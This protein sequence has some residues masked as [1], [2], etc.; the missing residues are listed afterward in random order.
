MRKIVRKVII[1]LFL[2]LVLSINVGFSE[3]TID[4]TPVPSIEEQTET[5]LIASLEQTNLIEKILQ[6]KELFEK[7]LIEEQLRQEELLKEQQELL[8]QEELNAIISVCNIYCD[9]SE[10]YFVDTPIQYTDEEKQLLAQCLF[11]EAG[12][13]SWECQVITLSAILNHCDDYGG[14]WVLDSVNHFEV[15]PYYR[16]KTPQEEQYEVVEYVLSGHRIADIK[17]FR[18]QYYHGFGTEMLN[19]DGVYFSK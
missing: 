14:L 9:S 7:Q 10:I 18:T 5:I 1:L 17:Y 12:S 6:Q 11:C 4:N 8:K 19:I 2:V 3:M 13:T 16:Y 15:A